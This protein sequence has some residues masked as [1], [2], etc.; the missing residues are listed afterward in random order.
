[1]TARTAMTKALDVLRAIR[2]LDRDE[3]IADPDV[4]DAI[5][6]LEAAL[7]EA[8]GPSRPR[9]GLPRTWATDRNRWGLTRG[10]RVRITAGPHAGLTGTF[11][12]VSNSSDVY[13]RIAT[14]LRVT[15]RA[16]HAAR[17]EGAPA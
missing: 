13:V 4:I 2:D 6:E 1:M 16:E 17:C 3:G 8:G 12:G 15:V 14:A 9:A 5:D 10:Q 7:R 11:D